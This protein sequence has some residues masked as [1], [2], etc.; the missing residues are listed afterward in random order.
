MDYLGGRV[1]ILVED[2]REARAVAH[3]CGLR[4]G[5]GRGG[6]QGKRAVRGLQ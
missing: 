1:D 2:V 3:T 4:G 5:D 6:L